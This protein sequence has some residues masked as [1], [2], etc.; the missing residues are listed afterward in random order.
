[1]VGKYI[2]AHGGEAALGKVASYLKTA[3]LAFLNLEGPISDKGT[4]L[5]WK[6]YTFRSRTALAQGLA[7]AGVDVVSMANNHAM[8]CGSAALLDTIERLDAAG[9]QHAGG[10][11]NVT[12]AR[13]PA[14]LNTKAGKVA[15][16]AFTDKYASGFAAGEEHAGVATIGDGSKVLEAVKAAKQQAD[17]VIVSFHWGTEYTFTA[18]GYQRSLAHKCVDAGADLV[19]GHHPHV[20]QG[21]EVYKNKLIAY[22]L[23]DFVFDHRPGPTGQAF[24][25]RVA[26]TPDQPPVARMI[27]IYL[28]NTYGIPAVVTGG[29]A[30]TILGRLTSLSASLGTKLTRSGDQL[31]FGQSASSDSN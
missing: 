13:T 14:I 18:A 23:G 2:D 3:D 29:T 21:V 30:D 11:K 6:E 16:L 4:K 28:D 7:S 22:S 26:L 25:L 19:L 9:V 15:V 12:A 27:P 1:M 5:S 24:I 20:I 8:D 10:G 31:W 17:Y